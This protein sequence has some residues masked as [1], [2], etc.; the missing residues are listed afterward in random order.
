MKRSCFILQIS[1]WPAVENLYNQD[2]L[3]EIHSNDLKSK[4]NES[5]NEE[6]IPFDYMGINAYYHD[7]YFRYYKII[8]HFY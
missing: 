5:I 4:G 6:N 3:N 7:T 1:D 2:G 8:D